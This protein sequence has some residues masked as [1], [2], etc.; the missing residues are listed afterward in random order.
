VKYGLYLGLKRGLNWELGMRLGMRI[1][2]V[3]E[4]ELLGIRWDSFGTI[5]GMSV[6]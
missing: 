4:E 3:D 1:R 2:F 5:L 6:D